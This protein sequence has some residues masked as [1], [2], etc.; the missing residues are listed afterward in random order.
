MPHYCPSCQQDFQIEPGFYSGA[1]WASFP[2]V[3]IATAILWVI[4]TLV[5]SVEERLTM[6]LI[7]T[8][9]FTLQPV[10]MR[11]GRSLWI[12][13]FIEYRGF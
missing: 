4:L 13:I 3:V 10:F 11:L 12:N 9:I 6:S 1:L 8:L 2:L 5:F 7:A